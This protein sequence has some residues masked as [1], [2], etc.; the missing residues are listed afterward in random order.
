MKYIFIKSIHTILHNAFKAL[1][2]FSSLFFFCCKNHNESPSENK[3]AETFCLTDT[4]LQKIKTDTVHLRKV[5]SQLTLSGKIQPLPSRNV[6]IFPLVSGIVKEVYVE[7]GDYVHQGQRLAQIISSEV[8]EF[9]KELADAEANYQIAK[10]NLDVAKDM[11]KSR[12]ISEKEM[13]SAQKEVEKAEAEVKRLKS[14][15]NIYHIDDQGMYTLIAPIDGYIISKNISSGMQIR[16]DN[17]EEILTI[18][19]IE[20]V[21]AVA[22]VYESD[23]NKVKP[24]Y[25]AEVTTIAYPDNVFKGTVDKIFEALDPVTRVMKIAIQLKNQNNLLKPEMFARVKIFFTEPKEYPAVPSDAVIFDNSKYYVVAYKDKCNI[26]IV[27]VEIYKSND[28]WAYIKKGI[29]P[30]QII[31]T[32][33]NLLVY[34]ALTEQ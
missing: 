14:V 33:N 26:S 7:L 17:S 5:E 21:W 23:M 15:F 10:K 25:K 18:A 6:R 22:N 34:D 20:N 11:F 31:I 3:N 8:A 1:V 27:P 30:G 9:E 12:L 16:S 13:I 32:K 24:G 29:Q 19:D 4:M 28:K 2:I